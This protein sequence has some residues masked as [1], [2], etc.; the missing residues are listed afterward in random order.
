MSEPRSPRFFTF[1]SRLTN[2][3]PIAGAVTRSSSRM[4]HEFIISKTA[5]LTEQRF[6][7]LSYKGFAM[8]PIIEH[9]VYWQIMSDPEIEELFRE[10][11]I[12]VDEPRIVRVINRKIDL[13]GTPPLM[14]P[15]RI[16]KDVGYWLMSVLKSSPR[17]PT[18]VVI[19]INQKKYFPYLQ[20]VEQELR[21]TGTSVRYY[22]YDKCRRDVDVSDT[23]RFMRERRDF[24]A[25]WNQCYFRAD[26]VCRAIDKILGTWGYHLPQKTFVVEGDTS[27][28]HITGLASRMIGSKSFCLQWGFVGTPVPKTGWRNMPFD[29]FLAWGEFF[30]ESIEDYNPDIQIRMVGHPGLEERGTESDSAARL[31]SES[32]RIILFAVQKIM[33]PFINQDDLERFM[34]AAIQTARDLPDYQI[35]IRSHP[36]YPIPEDVKEQYADIPNIEWHDYFRSTLDESLRNAHMCVTISSTLA[37][38]A[39]HYGVIPLYLKINTIELYLHRIGHLFRKITGNQY[40]HVAEPGSVASL[41]KKIDSM[42]PKP[43]YTQHLFSDTGDSAVQNI[44]SALK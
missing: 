43:F 44:V 41:I 24:P 2:P 31:S 36:N 28:L 40:P 21:D 6:G 37:L 19:P 33:R 15:L 39:L 25:F 32:P 23:R 42:K 29:R 34:E 8:K 10:D 9:K 3:D 38:E 1:R 30:R 14:Y 12:R 22:A 17:Q 7:D 35:R 27:I 5:E 20:K 16:V 18:D 4:L 13:L 26:T 11:P